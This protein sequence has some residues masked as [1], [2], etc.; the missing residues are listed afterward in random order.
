MEKSWKNLRK[1]SRNNDKITEKSL[2]IHGKIME[3]SLDFPWIN[4]GKFTE[5]HGKYSEKIMEKSF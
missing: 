3:K 4:H 2:K 1:F 5:N